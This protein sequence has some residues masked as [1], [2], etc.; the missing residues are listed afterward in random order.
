[1]VYPSEEL[2]DL[3]KHTDLI[4]PRSDLHSLRAI[5]IGRE[6]DVPI[7]LPAAY[8]YASTTELIT[9]AKPDILAIILAGPG[10]E[11]AVVAAYNVA[12]SWIYQECRRSTMCLLHVKRCYRKRLSCDKGNCRVS[13]ATGWNR[14]LPIPRCYATWWGVGE[15]E[16]SMVSLP[17]IL[18]IRRTKSVF[19]GPVFL[20]WC[21]DEER[22]CV[23]A[24]TRTRHSLCNTVQ[25][26]SSLRGLR[27]RERRAR[28]NIAYETAY[29][30]T[31]VLGLSWMEDY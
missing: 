12:W 6:Y 27:R 29:N 18:T 19:A 2:A 17:T 25:V 16:T 7:L 9:N 13:R 4:L 15:R 20:A 26:T 3:E 30:G 5:A 1:M 14:P 21:S 24:F 23:S 11:N 31:A 22:S 8:Y 10:R 28:E